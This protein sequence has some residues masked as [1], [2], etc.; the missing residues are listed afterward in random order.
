MPSHSRKPW[1]PFLHILSISSGT[2]PSLWIRRPERSPASW[3]TLT[4][5]H[6]LTGFFCLQD[7]GGA[8]SG[9][10]MENPTTRKNLFHAGG[11]GTS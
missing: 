5:G 4:Y 9:S 3:I 1:A 8:A 10:V 11:I 7:H 6:R 2:K